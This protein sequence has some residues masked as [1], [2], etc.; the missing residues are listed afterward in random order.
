MS[1]ETCQNNDED[2]DC[3]NS[4]GCCHIPIEDDEDA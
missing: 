3:M 2:G 4:W 1:C